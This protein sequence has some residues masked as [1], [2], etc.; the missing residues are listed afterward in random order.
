MSKKQTAAQ[1]RQNQQEALREQQLI[2]EFEDT[3]QTKI[4]H[5]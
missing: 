4:S 2:A 3:L 1:R 5:V